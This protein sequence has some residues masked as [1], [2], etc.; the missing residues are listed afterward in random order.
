M[1]FQLD[2]VNY[3][4]VLVAAVA[5]FMIGGANKFSAAALERLKVRVPRCVRVAS[6]TLLN[7]RGRPASSASGDRYPA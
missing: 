4:A 3:W 7:R 6:L 1:T 2:Q 5:T